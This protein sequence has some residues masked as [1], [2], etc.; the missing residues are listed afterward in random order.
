MA[1]KPRKLHELN[2]NL[3]NAL[4]LINAKTEYIKPK[5]IIINSEQSLNSVAAYRARDNIMFLV[6]LT[7]TVEKAVGKQFTDGADS[8]STVVHELLHWKDAQL[9]REKYG[10]IDTREQQER[11]I[12]FVNNRAKKALDRLEKDGYDV[13]KEGSMYAKEALK[14]EKFDEVY[15]EYRTWELLKKE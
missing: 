15:T 2:Q 8:L 11:Y 5:I 10:D 6:N 3:K 7:P 13:E 1:L 9:F 4:T 12:A 14:D